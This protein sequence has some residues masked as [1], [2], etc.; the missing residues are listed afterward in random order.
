MFETFEAKKVYLAPKSLMPLYGA[1]RTTGLVCDLGESICTAPVFEGCLFK[2]NG[3]KTNIGGRVQTDWMQKLLQG[4][5]ITLTSSL[6][7]EIVRDMKEKL[8]YVA[9]DYENEFAEAFSSSEKD[10]A[11]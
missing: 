4:V 2:Y 11:Y 3:D 10:I 1:G 5:G 6:E 8:C 9:Q 7:L